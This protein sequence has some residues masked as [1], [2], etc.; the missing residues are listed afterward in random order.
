MGIT[1]ILLLGFGVAMDATAV[2]L[3]KGQSVRLGETY[4][5]ILLPF[6]FG[7]FQFLMPVLGWV[8]GENLISYLQPYDSVVGALLLCYIALSMIKNGW[9]NKGEEG[10][11]DSPSI[12]YKEMFLLG[13][14]TSID[15][16]AIG[17]SLAMASVS[18][19]NVSIAM[20]VITYALSQIGM[21][22]SRK[23]GDFLQ[24]KGDILGGVALLF[25]A[26]K[27]FLFGIFQ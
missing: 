26:G 22:L 4:K 11:C 5:L 16:M 8:L 18:I 20:G 14:A 1:E 3:C 15:A 10:N 25:V 24:G 2:S 7:L 21:V 6:I 9:Q 17:A 19:L 27:I 23:M 12:N 13:I